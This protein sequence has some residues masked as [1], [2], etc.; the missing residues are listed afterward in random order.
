MEFLPI[1]AFEETAHSPGITVDIVLGESIFVNELL[2]INKFL[3]NCSEKVEH[4]VDSNYFRLRHHVSVLLGCH[5]ESIWLGDVLIGKFIHPLRLF[6]VS[7]PFDLLS[8]LAPGFDEWTP[9]KI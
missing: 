5:V 2:L 8:I 6:N 9:S 3:Q 4:L 7:V 1:L